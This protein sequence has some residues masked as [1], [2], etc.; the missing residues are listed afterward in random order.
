MKL[1]INEKGGTCDAI[2]WQVFPKRE[3]WKKVFIKVQERNIFHTV[4]CLCPIEISLPHILLGILMS[5]YRRQEMFKTCTYCYI[6][7]EMCCEMG[8]VIQRAVKC[9]LEMREDMSVI[10]ENIC[11]QDTLIDRIRNFYQILF[12]LSYNLLASWLLS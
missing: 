2:F 7:G 5:F 9:A 11:W 4:G 3:T 10:L 8:S 1:F 12:F 6:M